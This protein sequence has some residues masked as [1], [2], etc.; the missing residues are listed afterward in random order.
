MKKALKITGFVLL[1]LLIL[2]LGYVA[3]VFLDY[4]RIEDNLPLT[5]EGAAA[6]EVKAGTAYT[7]VSYNMGFGAYESDYSFFMD[8]GTESWAWSKERLDTNLK[9]IAELLKEQNA[10]FYFV[11]EVDND[12]TRSYHRNEAD[13]L[14][15]A[16]T[17]YSSVWGLNYDSPF[18]F[19]PLTQPHGASESGLMTF[20]SAPIAS[21]LR[22]SLPIETGVMKLVDL[23][24]C[25]TVSRVPMEN[26]KE[27][28]LYAVHLSAY[29]SD[30]V[31]ANE[32]AEMLLSDMQSEYE[33]G[34]YCICG[35]DFNKDLLGNSEEVFGVSAGDYTWAQPLPEE[36]FRDK[37]VTLVPPLD[38]ENPVPSCRNADAPYHEGQYVVTVDGFLVSDNV[39]IN[40][41]TVIDTGFAYSDHNP[42]TMTFTLQP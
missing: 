19:W 21:S 16:L 22:R 32:Q 7:V 11:E 9:N 41:A 3:Y 6:G 25:Y 37:N 4:H 39:I 10:D 34:N 27:L 31:I 8:G 33:K 35:G 28:V 17:G 40:S 15:E 38:P 1:A 23:D 18:L 2:V 13:L 42:V 20:S 24:R 29:T 26:G 30:G 14:R 5:A 36:L 12:A